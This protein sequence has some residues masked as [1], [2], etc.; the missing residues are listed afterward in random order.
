M[1][2]LVYRRVDFGMTYLEMD[3][4]KVPGRELSAGAFLDAPH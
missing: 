2:M 3:G 4:L 1:A